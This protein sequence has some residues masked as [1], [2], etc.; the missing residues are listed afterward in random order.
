MRGVSTSSRRSSTS[1]QRNPSRRNSVEGSLI[2][3]S[4]E[5][6]AGGRRWSTA[7]PNVKGLYDAFRIGTCTK[8]GVAPL[9]GGKAKAK[10]NQD[11][12]LVSWPFNSSAAEALMCIF[13]GHGNWGENISEFC[14][15]AMPLLLQ[16]DELTTNTSGFLSEAVIKLD[17]LIQKSALAEK[18]ETAGTTSTVVYLRGHE[19]WVAATGDSRAV[20]GQRAGD[21]TLSAKDL[22]HDHKPELPAEKARI[23]AAGGRVCVNGKDK[24]DKG[25]PQRVWTDEGRGMSMSR[26]LGDF[27]MRT[28]GVIPDPD[29]VHVELNPA[30]EDLPG[31]VCIIIASDGVWEF[32]SSDEAVKLVMAGENASDGCQK[33]VLAAKQKWEEEEGAYRDDITAV[34]ALLPL[35]N[36][37]DLDDLLLVEEQKDSII[38]LNKGAVGVSMVTDLSELSSAVLTQ[39]PG[40]KSRHGLSLSRLNLGGSSAGIDTGESFSRR[41]STTDGFVEPDEDIIEEDEEGQ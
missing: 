2:H 18:A 7:R 29:I 34:V 28:V 22:S 21:G 12:G 13:D 1:S 6:A 20:L 31:D 10:I 3:K 41:L 4:Q 26:S 39:G 11:R 36:E 17:E 25:G 27:G 33:L 23:V 24:D 38:E 5:L 32:I 35:F 8:H 9:P 19:C 30:P 40:Q 16:S 15:R 37:N 14:M